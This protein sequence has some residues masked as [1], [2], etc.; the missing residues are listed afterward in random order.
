MRFGGDEAE[1]LGTLIIVLHRQVPHAMH[2]CMA[3]MRAYHG[4]GFRVGVVGDLIVVLEAIHVSVEVG[5]LR[6]FQEQW[7]V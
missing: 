3:G 7:K 1:R 6:D 5:E 2:G 4:G